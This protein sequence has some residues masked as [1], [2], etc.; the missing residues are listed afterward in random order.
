MDWPQLLEYRFLDNS[1]RSWLLACAAFLFV[2]TVP[3][4]LRRVV[5]ARRR[6]WKSHQV[7]DGIELAAL[8]V[9]RT[10]LL[11]LVSAALYVAVKV[12]RL[13]AKVDEV[14]DVIIVLSFWFQVGIWTATAARFWL[15]RQLHK[16]GAADAARAGSF[17]VLLFVARLAIFTIVLMLALDNLGI[18]IKPLLAG[19]G[20]GGVA[21]ALAMQNLLGDLFASLSITLDKP[22]EIGDA[23][24]VDDTKGTVERIGIKST[25]LRSVDGEQIIVSNTDLLKSR[26]RNFKRM[27][28][29]RYAFRIGVT[30]ETPVEKLRE[31]PAILEAAVRAQQKTRFDRSHF[32][33]FAE[34]ACVFETVYF[35][36]DPDYLIFANAQQAIN[37]RV[38]E[39]FRARAIEFAYPTQRQIDAS[40]PPAAGAAPAVNA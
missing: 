35:V 4:L 38:M 25:R 20:I 3:P 28:E 31:I 22:F 17:E 14:F 1:L 13:P 27:R 26:V 40:P 12:L 32:T 8:L 36:T 37:L 11:V 39:Q 16:E 30:L 5:N 7:P 33:E 9:S 2:F 10:S 15:N 23:L 29:R 6:Q 24:V 18:Q 21:V 19:L 34:S